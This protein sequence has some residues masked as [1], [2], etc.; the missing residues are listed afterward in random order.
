MIGAI[1]NQT[2]NI[3]PKVLNLKSEKHGVDQIQ[4]PH[5]QPQED[6]WLATSVLPSA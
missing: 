6:Y 2:L 1:A 5:R 3:S 4:H